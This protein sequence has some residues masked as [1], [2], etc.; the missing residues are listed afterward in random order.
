LRSRVEA[1]G[2]FVLLMGNLGSHH[3]AIDVE[4]F[5]GFAL[6]DDVAP[7]LLLMIRMRNRLGHSL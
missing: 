1:A 7:L 3:S 5:R 4:A 2:I 6:A